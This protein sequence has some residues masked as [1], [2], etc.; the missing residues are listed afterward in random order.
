M[1]MAAIRLNSNTFGK[2]LDQNSIGKP[3]SALSPG[4][5]A[6][7]QARRIFWLLTPVDLRK[8]LFV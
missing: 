1:G 7:D 2:C 8:I 4:P 6:T 3:N 5:S